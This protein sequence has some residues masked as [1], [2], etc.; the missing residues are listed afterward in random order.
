MLGIET[1]ELREESSL[2][3][4]L[5]PYLIGEPPLSK[6]A[7]LKEDAPIAIQKKFNRWKELLPIVEKFKSD[8]RKLIGD[9][10]Y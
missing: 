6:T 9:Y 1:K 4:E 2:F 5:L 7:K 10:L 3:C 8:W